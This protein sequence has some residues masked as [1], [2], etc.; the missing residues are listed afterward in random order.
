MGRI[1]GLYLAFLDSSIIWVIRWAP[2][3]DACPLDLPQ[4]MT[5]S[6]RL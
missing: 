6:V 5:I 1:S 4:T 3:F 2:L